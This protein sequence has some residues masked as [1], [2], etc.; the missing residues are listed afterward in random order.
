MGNTG[1][2]KLFLYLFKPT[3]ADE[4]IT[5]IK[6]QNADVAAGQ[7]GGLPAEEGQQLN[8]IGRAHV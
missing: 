8:E 2:Q 5:A 6:A 3:I 4:I 7:L 1:T